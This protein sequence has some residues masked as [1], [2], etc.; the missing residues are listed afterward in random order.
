MKHQNTK[1][2]Q[3]FPIFTTHFKLKKAYKN[4]HTPP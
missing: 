3:F 1:K 4:D 2:L